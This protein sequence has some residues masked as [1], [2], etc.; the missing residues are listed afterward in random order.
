MNFVEITVPATGVTAL[1]SVPTI[2]IVIIPEVSGTA[3]FVTLRYFPL[4][5]SSFEL[6][7]ELREA[8]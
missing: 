1:P 4:R 7:S 8:V 5:R 3:Y 2:L 6:P